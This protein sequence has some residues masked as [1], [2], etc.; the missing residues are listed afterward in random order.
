MAAAV[1]SN[2]YHVSVEL[3]EWNAELMPSQISRVV[4]GGEK[5]KVSKGSTASG[6]YNYTL[7]FSFL[8]YCYRTYKNGWMCVKGTE[9]STRASAQGSEAC[10]V[11]ARIEITVGDI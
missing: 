10:G 4:C 6:R 5:K 7:S 2:N 3:P 9:A 11:I 8:V 1:F